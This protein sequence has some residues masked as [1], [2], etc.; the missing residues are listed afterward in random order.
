MYVHI[1]KMIVVSGCWLPQTERDT[2]TNLVAM[3][4]GAKYL[5]L[6]HKVFDINYGIN[7]FQENLVYS[8]EMRLV[9]MS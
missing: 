1:T 8:D 4:T 7:Y 9:G 6:Q 2:E 5:F 3:A